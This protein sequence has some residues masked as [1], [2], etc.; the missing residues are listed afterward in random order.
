MGKYVYFNNLKFT[1][2][3]KTGYYLNSSLRKRLHRY[4]WEYHNG[5]IP[6]GW[7]IH[8]IDGNKDNNDIS[9][10]QLIDEHKHTEYHSNIQAKLH[11]E[12][13]V[14]NLKI[15]VRPKASEWHRSEAGRK[16]HS[17]HGIEIAKNVSKR[18]YVCQQCG[19]KYSRKPFGVGKFCSNACKSAYRRKLGL[20]NVKKECEVCG[21]EFISNKYHK[22]RCCSRSCA[23]KIRAIK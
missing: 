12:K 3:D 16:W 14:E 4:V 2:D 11:Y 13:M 18:E 20:D 1:K 8:H 10:L 7:H 17:L 22:T 6:K 21:K 5:E 15:N 19:T 9:N 23:N